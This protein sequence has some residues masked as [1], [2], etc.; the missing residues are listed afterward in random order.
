MTDALH[1]KRMALPGFVTAILTVVVL[2]FGKPV[3]MPLALAAA[4]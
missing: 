2:Y 3:L 4:I 1:G